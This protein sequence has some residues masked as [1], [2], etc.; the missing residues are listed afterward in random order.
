MQNSL[1]Y[2]V[3]STLLIILLHS[4]SYIAR[5]TSWGRGRHIRV[6]LAWERYDGVPSFWK[7]LFCSRGSSW[8]KIF[9]FSS[10][11][12]LPKKQDHSL[13]FFVAEGDVSPLPLWLRTCLHSAF[14]IMCHRTCIC[15][16]CGGF[17][18]M[19]CMLTATCKYCMMIWVRLYWKRHHYLSKFPFPDEPFQFQIQTHPM[20]VVTKLVP[21]ILHL[22]SRLFRWLPLQHQVKCDSLLNICSQSILSSQVN[23]VESIR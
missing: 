3:K 1:Y 16:P 22:V 18:H 13:I 15:T 23:L 2:I 7:F 12:C 4:G 21:S 17:A 8:C 6:L 20:E 9:I 14:D 10:C 19:C 5:L 11:I